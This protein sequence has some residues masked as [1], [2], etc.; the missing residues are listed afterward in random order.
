M[1]GPYKGAFQTLI[2]KNRTLAPLCVCERRL[3]FVTVTENLLFSDISTSVLFV[4]PYTSSCELEIGM[5]CTFCRF[6]SVC[7]ISSDQPCQL[8]YSHTV[9]LLQVTMEV[10][11]TPEVQV[12][13]LRLASAPQ[14]MLG[15]SAEG[16]LISADAPCVCE[17]MSRLTI[18]LLGAALRS[19][20][21]SKS[22]AG[23]VLQELRR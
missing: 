6:V 8:T 12:Q 20:Y 10:L 2:K 11:G 21:G 14:P 23:S 17:W 9:S 1:Q 13:V 3:T 4:L 7:L 19:R 22:S 16:C 15:C 18:F 5:R